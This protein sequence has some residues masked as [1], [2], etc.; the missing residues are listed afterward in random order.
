MNIDCDPES[1]KDARQE[2]CR[3]SCV[4]IDAG[5]K[6]NLQCFAGLTL[7]TA[8]LCGMSTGKGKSVRNRLGCDSAGQQR[9]TH[10]QCSW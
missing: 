8:I 10:A 9:S 2:G 4:D 7:T 5:V 6:M 3:S 1:I